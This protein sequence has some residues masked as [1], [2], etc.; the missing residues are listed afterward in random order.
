MPPEKQAK[1]DTFRVFD[2]LIKRLLH[3]SGREGQAIV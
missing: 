1:R 2:L 3:L